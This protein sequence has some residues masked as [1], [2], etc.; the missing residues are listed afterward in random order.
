[1]DSGGRYPCKVAFQEETRDVE[2]CYVLATCR[3]RKQA[4]L[5]RLKTYLHMK[6]K[7]FL[8][9]SSDIAG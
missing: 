6:K 3:P 8:R 9:D 1:M 4:F 2:V 5:L 7:G